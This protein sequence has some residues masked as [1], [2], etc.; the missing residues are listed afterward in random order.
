MQRKYSI[1]LQQFPLLFTTFDSWP[2]EASKDL[3]ISYLISLV[4]KISWMDLVTH[5]F[6]KRLKIQDNN[7]N[8]SSSLG[9]LRFTLKHK[10]NPMLTS[11]S[12]LLDLRWEKLNEMWRQCDKSCSGRNDCPLEG[13]TADIFMSVKTLTFHTVFFFLVKLK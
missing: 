4:K 11:G 10:E 5:T 6:N 1:Y 9:L 8:F 12:I 13:L 7:R 3:V 2:L